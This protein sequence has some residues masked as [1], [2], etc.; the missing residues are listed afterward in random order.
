MSVPTLYEEINRKALETLE[1][2]VGR[3]RDG[4]I[5]DNEFTIALGT[6]YDCLAGL[7]DKEIVQYVEMAYI[8]ER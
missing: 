2:L 3:H 6:M 5:T 1:S 8:N 4:G 7:A